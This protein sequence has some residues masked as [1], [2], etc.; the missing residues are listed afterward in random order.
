MNVFKRSSLADGNGIP[1]FAIPEIVAL[2][3]LTH[4][5][6]TRRGGV[7]PAPYDSLNLG[8]RT[9]DPV[10]NVDA[11][12]GRVGRAFGIGLDGLVLLDQ[13]HGD[14]ILVLRNRLPKL[15]RPLHYD[16]LITDL[17]GMTLGIRTAD[18]LP[19]LIVDPRKK[20]VA[21]AHAGRVGTGLGILPRVIEE[22]GKAFGSRPGD[23]LVAL[24]PAI[25]LCCYEVDEEVFLPQWKPFSVETGPG[26]W[27]IDVPGFNLAQ[28]REAGV[29]EDRTFFVDLCT[30]CEEDLFFSHR[31]HPQT[32]RQLSF[33][34]IV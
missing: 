13:V 9:K 12:Y 17:A 18:C 10:E 5:F 32:G 3:W 34:G 23:L 19:A 30:R 31:R 25:G 1:H 2:G 22:M 8:Y 7:S 33:I 6:L 27:R 21:A 16:A 15:T 14:R 28:V 20:V 26:R 24:G 4:A 29:P 11:N